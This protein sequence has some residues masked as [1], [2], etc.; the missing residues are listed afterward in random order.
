MSLSIEHF[1]GFGDKKSFDGL[2][3]SSRHLLI[4]VF[5][6]EKTRV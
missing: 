6:F 4:C 1:A 2:E 5:G 3:V